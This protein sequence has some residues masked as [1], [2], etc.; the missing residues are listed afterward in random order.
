MKISEFGY[1]TTNKKHYF[2]EPLANELV[3]ILKDRSCKSIYDFGCGAGAYVTYFR[4]NGLDATGIDG[5]P[6]MAGI[7]FLTVANLAQPLILDKK[8]AVVCLEVGEHIPKEYEDFFVSNILN[9]CSNTLIISWARPK[10]K[11]KGHVNCKHRKEVIKMFEVHGFKYMCSQTEKIMAIA[12]L[13]WFKTN[14]I[15]MEKKT[16]ECKEESQNNTEDL[17]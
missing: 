4:Q 10:Q 1:W 14:L 17:K 6:A 15:I 3:K 2:D 12:S 9:C 5:N 16:V 8:D 11:G 7:E 13:E